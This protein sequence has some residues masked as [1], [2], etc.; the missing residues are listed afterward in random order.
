[1][2]HPSKLSRKQ[3]II[4]ALVIGAVVTAV[5]FWMEA[6]DF[7]PEAPDRFIYD[8]KVSLLSTRI[9]A[10]RKDIALIYVDDK[11]LSD[12]FAITP[13]DRALLAELIRAVDAAKPKVI[14]LD[15]V[16]DRPSEPDRDEALITALR[17]VAAPVVMVATDIQERGVS[18]NRIAWQASYLQRTNNM[19]AS[20]FLGT[21]DNEFF[22]GDDVIRSMEPMDQVPSQKLPF[23]LVLAQY[24]GIHN[25]PQSRIIDWL[26]PS[27]NGT[28]PF[29]TFIVPP[30]KK[31]SGTLNGEAVLPA[32]MQRFLKNRIVI[33]GANIIGVDRHRVP[34]TVAT[35]SDV[36]GAYI[37][38]QILAQIIDGRE[39]REL[40]GLFVI[41][42]IFFASFFL[43]LIVEGYGAD[44][45]RIFE[46]CLLAGIFAAGTL[47]FWFARINFPSSILLLAWLLVAFFGKYGTKITGR[48]GRKLENRRG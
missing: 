38:A 31:V 47:F 15:V 3:T 17:E 25:Y 41:P 35:N 28:E 44:Q 29:Q 24:A 20:P 12:Y 7:V 27:E 4:S 13:V 18:G 1:M 21:E 48:L 32:F 10:Q 16:F 40:P 30:H 11:S 46:F 6:Y 8:W 14:G 22:L 23:A 34:M 45:S 33:I 43:V 39:V 36:P 42:L 2:S 26:L 9:K 5:V 37:H 19:I